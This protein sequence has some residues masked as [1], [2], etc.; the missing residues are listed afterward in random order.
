MPKSIKNEYTKINDS[1]LGKASFII[2]IAL[3]IIYMVIYGVS[4]DKNQSFLSYSA[5]VFERVS[6]LYIFSFIAVTLTAL[7]FAREFQDRTIIYVLIRPIK[8]SKLFLNKIFAIALYVFKIMTLC[9]FIPMLPGLIIFKF[10]YFNFDANWV[11]SILKMALFYVNS[12]IS[13]FLPIIICVLISLISKNQLISI[14]STLVVFFIGIF[15]NLT[16]TFGSFQT[17]MSVIPY[18]VMT[19]YIEEK[20][21]IFKDYFMYYTFMQ[22]IFLLIVFV[23]CY[24]YWTRITK[25]A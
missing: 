24:R 3:T 20:F 17:K 23:L 9:F 18:I 2:S 12:L 6:L 8:A 1:I 5:E 21:N 25:H 4:L 22:A 7:L 13:I 11:D 15:L 10:Q 16:V 19:K 14:I